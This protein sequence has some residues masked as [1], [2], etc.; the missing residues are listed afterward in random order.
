MVEAISDLLSSISLYALFYLLLT[1]LLK[2]EG[3]CGISAFPIEKTSEY[4]FQHWLL[5]LGIWQ[6]EDIQWDLT[7]LI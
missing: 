2:D 5:I 6:N 4:P 3:K 7:P 1:L